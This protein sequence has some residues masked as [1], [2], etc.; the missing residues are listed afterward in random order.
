MTIDKGNDMNAI[1]ESEALEQVRRYYGEVLKSSRDLKTGAC[2]ATEVLPEPLRGLGASVHPEVRDRFYGCGAPLPPALDDCVVLDLGCGSGRDCY[3]LSQLVGEHGQV[4]GVDMTEEQLVVARRHLGWH[5]D[6]F[7]YTRPNVRFVEGF[8]EDL[9]TAGI[10]DD[11]VDIVISNCVINLSPDKGRV[12]AEMLRVLKPG[13]EFYFSDVFADRR[14]PRDLQ[15]DPVLRGECLG[16]AMYL[17][18]FRRL[19]DKAGC[20]DARVVSSSP[21][22]LLDPEIERKIGF[23]AFRSL[24]MRGFKLPLEDRCEDYGQVA[25]YLGTIEGQPHAFV[26][27]DHHRFER[28]RPMTVCGNTADM[29]SA[30]RYARHFQVAGNKQ[31]HFGLFP[32]GPAAGVARTAVEVPPC[33]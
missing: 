26:L 18:D 2:C 12:F 1:S 17:E 4:I 21:V 11:S 10:A 24:T 27:D 31:T 9:W 23:V 6:R 3:L 13:G 28:G 7:G 19:V 14:I 25:T 8:I 32:C 5:M 29:L 30:S 22:P 16:G 33:C 20:A 15:E